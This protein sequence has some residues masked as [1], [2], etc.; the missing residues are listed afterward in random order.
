MAVYQVQPNGQAPAGL[1]PGDYVNTAGGMY[2]ITQP[3]ALGSSYNPASG[4]WSIPTNSEAYQE[5][6]RENIVDQQIA[7]ARDIAAANTEQSQ[8]FAREQMLFQESSAQR[9]MQFSGEQAA[10]NREWQE[11]MS[12][13]AHQREVADLVAAGLNPILSANHA[14]ASTPSGASAAGVTSSGAQGTVDTSQ[15]ALAASLLANLVSNQTSMD[16]SKLQAATTMYAADRG[17]AGT[18]GAAGINAA[19]AWR[20]QQDSQEFQEYVY[21]N[22]PDNPYRAAAAAVA[23]GR[24]YINTNHSGSAIDSAVNVVRKIFPNAFPGYYSAGDWS[25]NGQ[26]E[27]AREYRSYIS[28][29]SDKG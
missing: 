23:A 24:D 21:R 2:Y 18:T 13:S 11:R 8:E 7:N 12:S 28:S 29:H 17:Y 3:G 6:R 27:V 5:N 10:L 26:N 1:S 25:K 4:Y 14:G 22:Y 20:L 15:N 19:S 16:I 9:A